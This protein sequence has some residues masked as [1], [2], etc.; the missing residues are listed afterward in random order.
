MKLWSAVLLLAAATVTSAA[1]SKPSEKDCKQAIETIRRLA[2][3][4][5][6][7][8]GDPEKAIRSCRANA[9]K[10]S[11]KCILS[12]K[13]YADLEKCEGGVF[14][15]MYG[16]NGAADKKADV[17]TDEKADVKTDEKADE[18]TDEKTDEKADVKTDEKA[19]DEPAP[20]PGESAPASDEE[21]P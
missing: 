11:V 4:D 8:F 5:S 6:D 18:K 10:K 19:G 2:G 1:C 13:T 7:D 20:K 21:T 16:K 3:T 9:S 12:A 17:K 14:D 15:D